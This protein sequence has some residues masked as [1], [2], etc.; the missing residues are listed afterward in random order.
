MRIRKRQLIVQVAA[1]SK[2]S[3]RAHGLGRGSPTVLLSW[4]GW[5]DA[6]IP[7]KLQTLHTP[8]LEIAAGVASYL[9]DSATMGLADS[10]VVHARA[11]IVH[12]E[13][14]LTEVTGLKLIQN[15]LPADPVKPHKIIGRDQNGPRA[16]E[17]A[18]AAGQTIERFRSAIHLDAA[19]AGSNRWRLEPASGLQLRTERTR[20][21]AE[22]SGASRAQDPRSPELGMGQPPLSRPFGPSSSP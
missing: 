3:E 8:L 12:L 4:A 14:H 15:V 16:L 17:A 22:A 9:V 13:R 6:A 19:G 7:P 20:W 1:F 2:W 18:R 5:I 10:P 11:L 21:L